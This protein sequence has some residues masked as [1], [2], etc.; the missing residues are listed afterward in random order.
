MP[1]L[2][3]QKLPLPPKPYP[4]P[5]PA[6]WKPLGRHLFPQP[7]EPPVSL[8]PIKPSKQARNQRKQ[9]QRQPLPQPQAKPA[10]QPLLAHQRFGH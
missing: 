6:P 5:E 4:Q 7:H 2:P 9:E 1:R 8:K 3:R 10:R